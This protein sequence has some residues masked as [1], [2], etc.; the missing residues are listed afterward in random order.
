MLSWHTDDVTP[1]KQQYWKY[2]QISLMWS[3]MARCAIITTWFHGGFRHSLPR[4]F[5]VV[6]RRC[7]WLQHCSTTVATIVCRRSNAI[8]PFEWQHIASSSH[9]LWS[10]ARVRTWAFVI[11]SLHG[12]HRH[13]RCSH[14]VWNTTPTPTIT[15]FIHHVF[16]LSVPP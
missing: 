12:R 10:A 4:H 1:W 7:I 11:Y 15:K 2:F 14:L 8:C 6:T 13:H 16:Q 3:P 9:Y 5:A